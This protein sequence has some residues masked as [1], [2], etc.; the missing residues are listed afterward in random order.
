MSKTQ[1]DAVEICNL[2]NREE[3]SE[4]PTGTLGIEGTYR[5]DGQEPASGAVTGKDA[6]P[7]SSSCI[8]KEGNSTR[9]KKKT[10]KSRQREEGGGRY[11]VDD[12]TVET[13]DEVTSDC[14]EPKAHRKKKKKKDSNHDEE[15]RKLSRNA[16]KKKRKKGKVTCAGMRDGGESCSEVLRL[17]STS[18]DHDSSQQVVPTFSTTR[19]E[20][21]DFPPDLHSDTSSS[22]L[23][24]PTDADDIVDYEGDSSPCSVE[25]CGRAAMTMS[26]FDGTHERAPNEDDLEASFF[27]ASVESFCQPPQN[28]PG[29][30]AKEVIGDHSYHQGS[31]ELMRRNSLRAT[32]AWK[33]RAIVVVGLV[34]AVAIIVIVAL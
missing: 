1:G 8:Q 9:K 14:K 27:S 33:S 23:P 3:Q 30:L 34:I 22:D 32:N 6:I 17:D 31:V 5:V 2:A 26:S 7:H 24:E 13:L 12:V 21:S 15:E 29:S 16:K 19:S 11:V 10:S 28:I 20:H 4:N 25:P 18:L